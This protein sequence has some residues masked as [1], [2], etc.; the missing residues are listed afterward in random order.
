M[1]VVVGMPRQEVNLLEECRK[2]KG[3]GSLEEDFY[4]GFKPIFM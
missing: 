1:M 2:I 4:N 3:C